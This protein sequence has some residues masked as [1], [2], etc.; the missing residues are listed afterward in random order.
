M[1]GYE[2]RGHDHTHAQGHLGH[3]GHVGHLGHDQGSWGTDK[4]GGVLPQK[5][6]EHFIFGVGGH[7]PIEGLR[8]HPA[9]ADWTGLR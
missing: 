4:S 8:G 5:R 1:L 3:L 6:R 9:Q 7:V 2:D